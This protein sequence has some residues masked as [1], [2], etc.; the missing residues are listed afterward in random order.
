MDLSL[1]DPL[2]HGKQGL[3][4]LALVD[5][6]EPLVP[7][8]ICLFQRDVEVRVSLLSRKVNDIELGIDVDQ[9]ALLIHDRKGG[10]SLVDE[11]V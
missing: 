2:H 11:L 5:P 9:S 4:L 10:D 3:V 7:V 6:L 1:D 8:L